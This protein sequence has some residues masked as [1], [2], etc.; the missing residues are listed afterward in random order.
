M[1]SLVVEEGL[2]LQL[3][4]VCK[5]VLKEVA[6]SRL[7]QIVNGPLALTAITSSG[8]VEVAGGEVVED[9]ATLPLLLPLPPAPSTV[10]F[11]PYLDTNYPFKGSR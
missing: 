10:V 6:A 2:P 5:G 1:V 7:C 4:S 3:S 8:K 9:A 11:N